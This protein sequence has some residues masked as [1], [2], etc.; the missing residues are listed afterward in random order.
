MKRSLSN[1]PHTSNQGV[2][3]SD[4]NISN[5]NFSITDVSNNNSADNALKLN[6]LKLLNRRQFIG[7]GVATGAVMG[8]MALIGCASLPKH[9]EKANIVI[10]GAGIAGLAVANRLSRQL[11]NAK[12][13]I[14]DSRQAHYYQPGYTLLATG[15]W[16]NTDKVT[17]SNADLIPSSIAWVQENAR[18]FLPDSNQVITDSGKK[19][20]YDY[21]VIATGLRLGFEQI[22]GLSI[23]DLGTDGIGSVYPSPEIALKTWHQIDSFRQKGGRAVMT[24]AHTDMKCAGAPLKMTF[25]LHDRLIQAGT[26]KDSDIQFFSPHKT[27]FSVPA[28]NENILSRWAAYDPPIGT[29]F[30]QRLTAID[31]GAKVAYFTNEQGT[32][33]RQDYDFIHVVPPMFAVDSVLNSPLANKKGWLDVDKYTLQHKHYDNIFGA[34]DINGTPKGK[35]A[36]TI[37]NS[38][39]IVTAN[40]IDVIQGN[41]P[42]QKFN[43]YTSCPLLIEEG[44]AMLVEFDYE[45]KLI[46]SVP[47]VDPLKE[48]YFAW[49][50]EEMML[51]PA[52]MAVAK[53]RV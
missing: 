21:L 10:V 18:E 6:D 15:V 32:Q 47:L 2:N 29:N 30:E 46:P 35:T 44:R 24:L 28:V 41:V 31:K 20:N 1:S 45:N 40:L 22:E 33:S 8:S 39:P 53:G 7:A 14:L 27:V 16:N 13:T 36:A 11:P 26:R 12:L 42:S 38:A 34:G 5:T 17:D 19:I 48:S 37:K 4:T 3:A 52:Y 25:M 9:Q 43:G 49:F 23:E 51:K 50:L